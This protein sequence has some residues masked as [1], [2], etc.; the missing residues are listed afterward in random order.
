MNAHMI[1]LPPMPSRRMTSVKK[2]ALSV[3][4]VAATIEKPMSHHGMD[5]PEVKKSFAVLFARRAAT[6]GMS[7][8]TAKNAAMTVQSSPFRSMVRWSP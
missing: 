3:A 2:F 1:Q 7:A 8:R 6:V 5:F 4:V